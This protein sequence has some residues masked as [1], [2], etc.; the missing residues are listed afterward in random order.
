MPPADV[1]TLLTAI[2]IATPKAS[3]VQSADAAVEA[4]RQIGFPV[5][6]KATG[7]RIVHK[8]EL[9]AVAIDLR[10][11]AAVRTA[12]QE[13]AS[14]LGALMTGGLVQ[15]MI[16]GGVEMLTGIVDDAAF[17]AVVALAAGGTRAEVYAD[18]QFRFPPMT[19]SDA[20]SMVEG[21]RSKALLRR[22]RGAPPADERALRDV[23]L[24]LSALAGW[25][26]EIQELDINPLI[27]RESGVCAIDTR[28]RVNVPPVR[29]SSRRVRY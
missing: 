25:C 28:V 7:D 13:M 26:P 15:E 12:W 4:S 21:L 22:F 2:G 3:H 10:D 6:L 29:A 18:S 27:V 17:G 5:V 1:Q 9:R 11:E 16:T 19:E 8:T 14:R 20:A 24:R 23:L